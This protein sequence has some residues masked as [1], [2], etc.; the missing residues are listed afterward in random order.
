MMKVE[1]IKDDSKRVLHEVDSQTEKILAD[2]GE[3]IVKSAKEIVPVD[4]GALKESITYEVDGNSVT[5]GSPLNYSVYV[6]LGTSK[7]GAQP[8]LRPAFENNTSQIAALAK[9]GYKL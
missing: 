9:K 7:M 1:I 8:Y 2:I 6:E 5:V 4:T 3:L